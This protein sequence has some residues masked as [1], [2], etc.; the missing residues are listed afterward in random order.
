MRKQKVEKKT[1][2]Q[3]FYNNYQYSFCFETYKIFINF[4]IKITN[5]I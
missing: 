2:S 4:Y 1:Y 3:N 5:N